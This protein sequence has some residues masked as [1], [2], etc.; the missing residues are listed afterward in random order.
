MTAYDFYIRHGL[1]LFTCF[2]GVPH[3]RRPF[4]LSRELDGAPVEENGDRLVAGD[5][6]LHAVVR[7]IDA[8][9]W[10]GHQ[11]EL[12]HELAEELLVDDDS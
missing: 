5:H 6:D 1:Q 9:N 7:L 2:I 12:V 11:K 8:L 3:Q 4:L 10:R